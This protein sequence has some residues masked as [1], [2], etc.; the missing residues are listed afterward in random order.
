MPRVMELED[1]REVID[2]LKNGEYN[3]AVIGLGWMG[4][5]TA[6]LYARKGIRVIGIDINRK[7]VDTINNG[8]CHLET[9]P[10]L[11][12]LVKEV[13]SKGMLIATDD[14]EWGISN[15]DIIIV[16]VP[17]L[18]KDHEPDYRALLDTAVSLGKAMRKGSLV[19]VESTVGPG[20]TEGL[21]AK[22]I[23]EVRSLRPGIDYG[24]A[25][26]PIRAM[27]GRALKDIQSYPRVLG[28]IDKRSLEVAEAVLSIIVK[29]GIIK[30][31]NIRTAEAVK[32]AENVY[33][34][35]N[36]AL[37]NQLA[38]LFEQLNIDVY[39]VVRAANTQPYAHLH[40]PGI[41]VGGHCIPINPYF[42]L[43]VAESIGIKLTL[44]EEARKIN[45]SMP[46]HALS[47]I[48][49][50]FTRVKKKLSESK[51]AILGLSYRGNVKEHRYSP[52]LVLYNLLIKKAKE[53][54]IYD[55]YYNSEE[56]KK[57][58]LKGAQSLEEAIKGSDCI[59]IATDHDEFRNLDF[60]KIVKLMN[61]S[62]ILIEGRPVINDPK[63]LI[64]L[65]FTYLGIGRPLE[66][67]K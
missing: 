56:L 8:E 21:F 27:A 2:K 14:I 33:R 48:E 55:P 34:D 22:K 1:P 26:S 6:C 63:E 49:S 13:V 11:K 45:D 18:I 16:V 9:E 30:V 44:I 67:I 62:P 37:V 43:S 41:G 61:E 53:V 4:L 51:I 66:W 31:S 38:I 54:I 20:V 7:V 58:G 52:S 35:V 28:A 25:Y 10:K 39:E 47:L 5:P 50:A 57:L 42:I 36:I 65:G 17:T 23:S 24:L 40:V 32:L 46:N 3:I 29:G 15:S 60:K 64:E 19:I 59:V 12:I